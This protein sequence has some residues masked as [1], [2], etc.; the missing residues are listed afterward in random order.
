MTEEEYEEIQEEMMEEQKDDMSDDQQDSQMEYQEGYGDFPQ[1]EKHN[2]HTF[3]HKAAF[4]DKDTLRVT[5]LDNDE[6]GKPIFNIRFMLDMEDIAKFYLDDIC[7]ELKID[8]VISEYFRRKI[9][10]ITDSGMSKQ[11][12][13]M[14]LNTTR[15]IDITRTKRRDN[16]KNLQGGKT[17]R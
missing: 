6:L 10:N 4:G 9:E 3:L 16:L 15:N 12:F 7:K 11:G 8:N 14:K 2:A 5:Y 17:T 13:S 1:E